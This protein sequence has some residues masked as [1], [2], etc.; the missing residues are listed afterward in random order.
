[1]EAFKTM[2]RILEFIFALLGLIALSPLLLICL[3][4]VRSTSPGP[5]LFKQMRIGKGQKPFAIYKIRTMQLGTKEAGTHLVAAQSVTNVGKVL[6]KLRLDEIPQLYNVLMGDMS[7]VGPRPCLPTQTELIAARAVENVYAVRPG[8][9]GLAQIQGL[10][11][12]NP[13]ELAK[14]DG[15]YVCTRSLGLDLRI[16]LQTILGRAIDTRPHIHGQ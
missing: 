2:Y 11:M 7:L 4:A 16:I 5:A 15:T 9:T 10:D 1:M 3:L 12:S 13:V 8:I 14:V 6:R